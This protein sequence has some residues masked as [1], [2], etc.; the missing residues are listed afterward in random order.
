MRPPHSR[1]GV[2]AGG[3]EA[4]AAA[5]SI[6]KEAACVFDVVAKFCTE[7]TNLLKFCMEDS[8]G[9]DL[10][11]GAGAAG[12][13]VAAGVGSMYTSNGIF[14]GWAVAVGFNSVGIF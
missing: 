1:G 2:Y 11:L 8:D 6:S 3:S 4:A 9:L 5:A 12:F 10:A 13:D 7:A 14:W